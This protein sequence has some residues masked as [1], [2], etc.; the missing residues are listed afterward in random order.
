MHVISNRF[1]ILDSISEAQHCEWLRE[2]Y[3]KAWKLTLSAFSHPKEI[4]SRQALV[5]AMRLLS[6][7]CRNNRDTATDSKG[8]NKFPYTNYSNVLQKLLSAEKSNN[9]LL[10][11][12]KEYGAY[13]DVVFHTWKLLPGITYKGNAASDIYIENYLDLLNAIPISAEVQDKKQIFFAP[14]EPFEFDYPYVRKNLNKVWSCIMI[15]D[16]SEKTHKQV[17][18]MLLEKVLNHLD[19]PVLLTDFLM[20]SLD[21][22]EY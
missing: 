11:R 14:D 13:L 12:F 7:E 6:V 2:Q 21:V 22:G 16:F 10:N 5:T 8:L 1:D 18:I 3:N 4:E 19:R 9:H 17:L 15:W 20:D